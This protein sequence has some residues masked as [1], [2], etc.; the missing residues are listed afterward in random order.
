MSD[1]RGILNQ[2]L[3]VVFVHLQPVHDDHLVVVAPLHQPSVAQAACRA[4]VRRRR[5]AARVAD[6]PRLQP[7][8]QLGLGHDNVDDD[9]RRAAV[10]D[11]IERDRLHDG[12]R[13][14][15]ENE[16]VLGVRLLQPIA[17]D[18]HHEVVADEL[19]AIH[20]CRHPF[21]DLGP[22]VHGL[23]QDVSGR[24]LRYPAGPRETLRLRSFSSP[25]RAEHHQVQGHVPQRRPR[26]RVFFMKPS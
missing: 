20:D 19:A 7:A 1:V 5:E 22:V 16:P 3:R 25:W 26:M 17:H 6:Q 9:E 2:R 14:P 11:G 15:V 18:P 21:A 23:A 4:V 12:P 10:H 8:D 13:K 24:N